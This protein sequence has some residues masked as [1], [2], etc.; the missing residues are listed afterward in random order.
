MDKKNWLKSF[1]DVSTEL[2]KKGKKGFQKQFLKLM[3]N[4]VFGKNLENGRKN[5]DSKLVTIEKRRGYFVSE[6]NYFKVFHRIFE[7]SNKQEYTYLFRTANTI[8]K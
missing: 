3:N 7:I 8:I 4:A 5:N 6:P 1:I 2:N